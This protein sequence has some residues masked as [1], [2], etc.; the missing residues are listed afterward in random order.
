VRA[1]VPLFMERGGLLLP[2]VSGNRF[3]A[4]SDPMNGGVSGIVAVGCNSGYGLE[5]H[6]NVLTATYLNLVSSTTTT[7]F[8]GYGGALFCM[9]TVD[10]NV[11]D[12]GSGGTTSVGVNLGAF[13][14]ASSTFPLRITNNLISA[15]QGTKIQIGISATNS[16]APT[17]IVAHNAILVGTDVPGPSQPVR[18]GLD[19]GGSAP[20][21]RWAGPVVNNVFFTMA[22]GAWAAVTG[23]DTNS[24]VASPSAF[25]NN[26]IVNTLAGVLWTDTNVNASDTT[27]AGL[28]TRLCAAPFQ[29]RTSGNV[30]STPSPGP[31]TQLS[32]LFVSPGGVDGD[33]MTLDDNDWHIKPGAAAFFANGLDTTVAQCAGAEGTTG[34][35]AG[36]GFEP[37]GD[38][39]RDKDGRARPTTPAIGPYEP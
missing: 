34:A 36:T 4:V 12:G 25:Q 32:D 5:M 6:D 15:G 33:V 31:F 37:C 38:V 26:L 9:G 2:V 20:I 3:D 11:I 18:H 35:C 16:I 24:V 30:L 21:G 7:G 14:A 1:G 27:L 29:M 13:P 17:A 23:A 19:C 22:S 39:T 10:G 8:G 28:T